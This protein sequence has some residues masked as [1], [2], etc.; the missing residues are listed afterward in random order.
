ML[1]SEDTFWQNSLSSPEAVVTMARRRSDIGGEIGSTIG[2]I[3]ILFAITS[4]IADH[5]EINF[6]VALLI[7]IAAWFPLVFIRKYLFYKQIPRFF[8]LQNPRY[9]LVLQR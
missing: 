2:G 9:T 6:F 5:F 8:D 4:A 7:L 1:G 3:V